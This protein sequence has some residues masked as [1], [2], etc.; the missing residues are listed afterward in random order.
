MAQKRKARTKKRQSK[1]C[2]KCAAARLGS[3]GPGLGGGTLAGMPPVGDAAPAFPGGSGAP[4]KLDLRAGLPPP[5]TTLVSGAG[6]QPPPGTAGATLA[7]GDEDRFLE[8]TYR[9]GEFTQRVLTRKDVFALDD[10][11]PDVDV[12]IN[13]ACGRIS[14]QPRSGKR[15]EYDGAIPG[16][17]LD[18]GRVL[19]EALMW[20][21]GEL[22][23]VED[24]LKRP[25]LKSFER[26]DA[27]AAR[28]MALR[29]GFGDTEDEPWYLLLRRNPWRLC[30]NRDRSWRIVERLAQPAAQ[31]CA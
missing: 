2:G 28:L 30:W 17:G 25:Q 21:P 14:I 3:R 8:T 22:L 27:R 4:D 7:A 9:N 1:C 18:V 26:S 16:V 23:T 19:L 11:E 12:Y 15:L 29:A 10:G 31:R 20:Q 13:E 6:I 5:A 24:L